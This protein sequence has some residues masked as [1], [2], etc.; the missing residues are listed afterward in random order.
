M[1]QHTQLS[2]IS[3]QGQMATLNPETQKDQVLVSL[4][5]WWFMSLHPQH[6][7]FIP[8][9]RACVVS[10][11]DP[12]TLF[13]STLSDASWVDWRKC[14]LSHISPAVVLRL[15]VLA[16]CWCFS[17]SAKT[18]HITG[19]DFLGCVKHLTHFNT[20]SSA[21]CCFV[22]VCRFWKSKTDLLTW[23]LQKS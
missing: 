20:W 9:W 16:N 14:G 8:T 18:I 21:F 13:R 10:I 22:F 6:S 1:A 7:A 2:S 11:V 12:T 15:T 23:E 4:L 3:L 19:K 5:L 17:Q